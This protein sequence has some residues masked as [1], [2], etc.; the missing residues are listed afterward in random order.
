MET[1][2]RPVFVADVLGNLEAAVFAGSKRRLRSSFAPPPHLAR[3]YVV[4]HGP[5][6]F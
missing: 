3:A 2:Q 1:T 5:E 6:L 4:W